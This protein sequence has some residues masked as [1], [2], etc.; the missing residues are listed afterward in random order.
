L[1]QERTARFTAR[2]FSALVRR[3][4]VDAKGIPFGNR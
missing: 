1:D 3:A 2:P 4:K